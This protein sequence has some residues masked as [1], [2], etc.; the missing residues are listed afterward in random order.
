[1]DESTDRGTIKHLS[2]VGSVMDKNGDVRDAFLALVPV[3][4]ASASTL[5]GHIKGVFSAAEI[6][7]TKNMIGFAAD[8]ANVMMGA[9]H[10]VASLLQADI[11]GIL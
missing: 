11:P 6:P 7:Y 8:G 10:S 5:F 1:M 9:H 4:N 2:L 3:S